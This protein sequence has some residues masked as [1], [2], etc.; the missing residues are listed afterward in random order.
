MSAAPVVPISQVPE[1]HK[2]NLPRGKWMKTR[3]ADLVGFATMTRTEIGVHCLVHLDSIAWG[4]PETRNPIKHS[5]FAQFCNTDD[6]IISKAVSKCAQEYLNLEQRKGRGGYYYKRPRP[7]DTDSDQ[8]TWGDCETCK[9]PSLYVV[10]RDIPIPHSLFSD[11]FR[12]VDRGVFLIC[13]LI[14]QENFRS[15]K[16]GELW[17]DPAEIAIDDFKRTGLQKSEIEKDL[18]IGEELGLWKSAGRK[19]AIQ[20][21]WVT[22]ENWN[23]VSVK[24]KRIGGNPAPIKR[25]KKTEI[26]IV[27]PPQ[28]KP[29]VTK[30]SSPPE[31]M[32]KP[33]GVCTKCHTWAVIKIVPT[34][35]NPVKKPLE[36]ARAGP[37]PQPLSKL[38]T[39]QRDP[40]LKNA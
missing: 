40:W 19:G 30:N 14:A 34:P 10:D 12:A 2:A 15:K 37:I 20:T 36:R 33:C 32:T 28:V 35:E 9:E 5:K 26:A 23:S 6:R 29:A 1:P 39:F 13:F 16:D 11:V 25:T 8:D 7:I 17:I 38:A 31:F 27:E 22:P 21:Y 18:R 3:P 4:K 24:P